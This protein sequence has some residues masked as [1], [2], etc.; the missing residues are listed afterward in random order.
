MC[1]SERGWVS[2]ENTGKGVSQANGTCAQSGTLQVGTPCLFDFKYLQ[3]TGLPIP[4]ISV[5]A[6]GYHQCLLS[7]NSLIIPYMP[8][9]TFHNSVLLIKM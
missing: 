1:P 5:M 6:S 7:L 3:S 9:T 2:H 8:P 4:I